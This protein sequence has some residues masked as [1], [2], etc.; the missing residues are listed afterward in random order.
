VRRSRGRL[1]FGWEVDAEREEL[2]N[3]DEVEAEREELTTDR[4][5]GMDRCEG[6][7]AEPQVGEATGAEIFTYQ[8]CSS[9]H[10]F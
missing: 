8:V 4:T 1:G 9:L 7:R 2:T 6:G 3:G 5:T 10:S